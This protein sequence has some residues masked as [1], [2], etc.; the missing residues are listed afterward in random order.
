MSKIK[1]RLQIIQKIDSERQKDIKST[2]QNL[3]L[4]DDHQL[5][6]ENVKKVIE[7][8]PSTQNQNQ[9]TLTRKEEKRQGTINL[10]ALGFYFKKGKY[11]LSLLVYFLFVL[12]IVLSTAS[13]WWAG[14]W[15]VDYFGDFSSDT[16]YFLGFCL[17]IIGGAVVYIMKFHLI[18]KMS[19]NASFNIFKD[20]IWNLLRRKMSF[21]DT[22]PSGV[23]LNRCIDDMEIVDYEY[24]LN[25]KDSSESFFSFFGA[26]VV[27]IAGSLIM[28]PFI[29]V[30]AILGGILFLSYIRSSIDLKR[31]Y[32][33]SRS[34]VLNCVS[35]VV[36]GSS[37]IRAY[38][39][40]AAFMKKWME[41][42]N[43]S[44]S[45]SLHERLAKYSFLLQVYFLNFILLILM[46]F[47]FFIKKITKMEFVGGSNTMSLALSNSIST[48]LLL[49]LLAMKLG[50]MVNNTS[51]I[52]RLQD[53][54]S[55]SEFEADFNKPEVKK[56]WPVDG[57]IKIDKLR[58]KY[59]KGLP[60]VLNELDFSI[61]GGQ[62]VGIVG[63]TGSGKSTLLLGL[64]RILEAVDDEGKPQGMIKIDDVDIAGIGLHVLRRNITVI[65]QDPILL[66]GTLRS[67]L[68][69]MGLTSDAEMMKI[70]TVFE[71][72]YILAENQNREKQS[73]SKNDGNQ[74]LDFRIEQRGSNLSLGQRQLICIARALVSHPKILL[75]DE[76]TASI[77]QRTDM[78][79]Q[80][81]IKYQLQGVTVVT[82]AH[83][84]ETIIQYDSILVLKDGRKVE[85]GSPQDLLA[86]KGYFFDMVREA[87][88]EQMKR[89]EYFSKN[90]EADMFEDEDESA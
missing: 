81:V 75:M 61:Q 90:K 47:V 24:A 89:M 36:E 2:A 1:K 28:I 50:D 78:I 44:I 68:D 63:R 22:T 88:E 60:F 77:D 70:L 5:K 14:A 83:R 23:I 16:F 20:M 29:L 27:T 39:Y 67:N 42:H 32:R 86:R 10:A 13:D 6:N 40:E 7:N 9:G 69:P 82:I 76:A 87:G 33:V 43:L 21:F 48:N 3:S 25:I 49:Y 58:L 80:K 72:E 31:L 59:R 84:L 34:K 37:S 41:A 52:E 17:L 64:T 55:W 56:A 65:P 74:I 57:T 30:M 51:V 66:E 54:C 46:F 19:C 26:L 73:D 45:V 85:E 18:G 8:Q 35:E 71:L 53:Y 15:I 62:K 79:I 12:S 4:R 38:D 11:L